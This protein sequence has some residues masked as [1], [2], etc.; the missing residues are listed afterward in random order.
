MPVNEALQRAIT[1]V[2]SSGKPFETQ[3]VNVNGVDFIGFVNAP[4]N[5]RELYRS[6]LRHDIRLLCL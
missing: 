2:T 3:T 5:L 4:T 6:G 1:E